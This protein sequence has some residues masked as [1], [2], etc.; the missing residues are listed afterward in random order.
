MDIVWCFPG[1]SVSM[2]GLCTI[3][4]SFRIR[5][6][7][8]GIFSACL[9]IRNSVPQRSPACATNRRIRDVLRQETPGRAGPSPVSS[10][11][12][13]IPDIPLINAGN[14]YRENTTEPER[15]TGSC[16]TKRMKRSR[17]STGRP[18]KV[19]RR[20]EHREEKNTAARLREREKS[21]S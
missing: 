10:P 9:Y 8:S 19:Y 7:W 16:L 2:A 3:W 13:S 14:G 15:K 1:R 17:S 4:R 6:R 20:K 18:G 12:R 5:R 21:R 11:I